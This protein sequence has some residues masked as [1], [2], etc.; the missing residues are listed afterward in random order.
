M[1]LKQNGTELTG[2][3]GPNSGQQ[4]EILKGKIEGN[5]VTFEVQTD[6]P[7][8]KFELML[9]DGHLKGQAKAEH[10]GMT[11][12]AEVDLQRKAD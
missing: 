11:M 3:A 6:Q 8:I 2:T 5:K 10:E 9:I 4:W 1:V 7:L 12:G